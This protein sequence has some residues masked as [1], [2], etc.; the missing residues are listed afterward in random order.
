MSEHTTHPDEA[1]RARRSRRLAWIHVGI[2]LAILG[3][4]FL[5]LS[6]GG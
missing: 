6:I 2:V 1:G 5:R 4:F 3:A